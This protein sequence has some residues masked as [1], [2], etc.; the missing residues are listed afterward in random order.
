MEPVSFDQDCFDRLRDFDGRR[1]FCFPVG[2]QALTAALGAA[3]PA[4]RDGIVNY[5]GMLQQACNSM[6]YLNL[7]AE[8]G[9]LG[10]FGALQGPSLGEV[11]ERT[12]AEP[13]LRQ[14]L[15]LHTLLHGVPAADIPFALHAGIVGLYYRSVHG[16]RGGGRSLASA[17]GSQI[18]RSGIDLFTGCRALGLKWSEAGTLK[19]VKTDL[20]G[21][22]ECRNCVSSIH[23]RG[24]LELTEGCS[25]RPAYRKRLLNLEETDSAYLGFFVADRPLPLL[26][27]GNLYLAGRRGPWNDPAIPIEQRLVYLAGGVAGTEPGPREFVA[28]SPASAK[29]TAAWSASRRG[30]RPAGYIQ[31]KGEVMGRLQDRIERQCPELRGAISLSAGATPLTL[32]DYLGHPGAGLYGVSQ[33]LG[34]YNPQAATR[35]P[36]V[37]LTGQATAAPGLLGGMLAGFLTCGTILGHDQLR[38]EVK[39]CVH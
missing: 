29:E 11:L 7:D 9:S 20:K 30:A 27:G 28:I 14:L 19:G 33:R 37:F 34:Q 18:R 36:G 23:P 5:L 16:I 31:F 17:F 25:L 26:A 4:E 10:P 8:F 2:Y 12:V 22:L 24:F 3:F 1:D 15:S 32:R 35:L 38:Q 6:P 21:L 39:R 13:G